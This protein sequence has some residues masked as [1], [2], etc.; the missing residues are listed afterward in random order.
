MTAAASSWDHLQARCTR[1]RGT[2]QVDSK[3]LPG[4]GPRLYIY[5]QAIPGRARWYKYS[6]VATLHCQDCTTLLCHWGPTT[7]IAIRQ[8]TK[9]RPRKRSRRRAALLDST[10]TAWMRCIVPVCV[11]SSSWTC[12]WPSAG[13][14]HSPLSCLTHT[15]VT[16]LAR[17]SPGHSTS[18]R[19]APSCQAQGAEP[20]AQ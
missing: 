8:A 5:I 15:E 16:G 19:R 6:Q 9:A 10:A 20:R 7:R 11:Q 4:P 2:S 14:A 12:T 13:S 18:N 3:V 1:A 17:H